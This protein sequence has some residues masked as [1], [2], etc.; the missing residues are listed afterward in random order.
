MPYTC[1]ACP[2]YVMIRDS[3][4]ALLLETDPGT[5]YMLTVRSIN[6]IGFAICAGLLGYAYYL[7]F[8]EY[9]DPCP[10]CIFQRLAVIAIG[11]GFLVASLHNAGFTARRVYGVLIGLSGLS[12]A[13]IAGR[14]VYLQSLPPGDVPE[15]GPGLDFMLRS[16]PL[17]ETLSK[18]FTGSGECAGIDWTFLTLSMPSWVLIWCVALGAFGLALNWHAAGQQI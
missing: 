11:L 18:V 2:G 14:H 4:A 7:Q 10:L 1:R 3:S 16:L 17:N 8:Y 12:G 15:C 6:F 5:R 9:L 13:A